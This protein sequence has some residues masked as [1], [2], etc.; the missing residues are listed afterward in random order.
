MQLSQ[1]SDNIV[2]SSLSLET[3]DI[4]FTCYM[5]AELDVIAHSVLFCT[6]LFDWCW[7]LT[8]IISIS[9]NLNHSN[10]SHRESSAIVQFSYSVA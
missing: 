4:N 1:L 5:D 3:S 8:P 9:F 6:V 7:S 2:I 10:G